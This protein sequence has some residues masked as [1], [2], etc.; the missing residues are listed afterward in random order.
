MNAFFDVSLSVGI[1]VILLI[2][3][4]AFTHGF[5]FVVSPVRPLPA[6]Q[7]HKKSEFGSA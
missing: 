2:I 5:V 7:F 3:A 1:L 4:A 6:R